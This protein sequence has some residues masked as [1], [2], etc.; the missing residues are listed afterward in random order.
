MPLWSPTINAFFHLYGLVVL[1][2]RQLYIVTCYLQVANSNGTSTSLSTEKKA[3]LS[4][5][6]L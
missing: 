5:I 2:K 6:N 1:K 3:C 4:S